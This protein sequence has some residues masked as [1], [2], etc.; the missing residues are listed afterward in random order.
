METIHGRHGI[1]MSFR[2]IQGILDADVGDAVAKLVLLVINHHANQDTMIAFPSIKTIAI[3]CNLSERTVIRK[4][5]YLVD[6][7]YLIR[8]R[9]G[10]NQ[11]NIYR[12]RKCQ[13]VTMEVT[14]CHVEG[15]SVSHEPITNQP[16]NKVGKTNGVTVKQEQKSTGF[17]KPNNY[18]SKG[19]R[20]KSSFFFGI[21]SKLQGRT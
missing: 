2:N 11:V 9:Q 10:K 16:S 7:K 8:K 4:L 3:K 20:G 17:T 21:N 13:P 19:S 6:K 18:K 5:E 12:V 1:G 15:V 14:E